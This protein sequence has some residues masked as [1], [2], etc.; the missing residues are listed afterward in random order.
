[1]IGGGRFL[2][3]DVLQPIDKLQ[4]LTNHT[5]LLTPIP[6]VHDK[7]DILVFAEGLHDGG[8]D[9]KEQGIFIHPK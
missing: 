4:P 7:P 6:T 5:N 2:A 3:Q 1:M 9:L 8:V